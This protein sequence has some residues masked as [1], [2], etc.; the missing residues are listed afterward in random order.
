MNIIEYALLKKML[1][2][3][4]ATAYHLT[5]VDELPTDAVDGSLAVVESDSL[6][7]E[8][9]WKDNESPLDVSMLNLDTSILDVFPVCIEGVDAMYGA[10]STLQFNIHDGFF[11]IYFNDSGLLY[12]DGA[13]DDTFTTFKLYTD[14]LLVLGNAPFTVDDFKAFIKTNCNRLSGGHT[15]YSRENGEWV[16]KGEI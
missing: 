15:L 1:G 3:G 6:F 12:E 4:G 13:F 16:S 7:G 11:S 8:W 9:E 14:V 5:S 10:F 2:S